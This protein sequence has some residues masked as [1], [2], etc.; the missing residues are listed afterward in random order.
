MKPVAILIMLLAL[1]AP[2]AAQTTDPADDE[3]PLARWQADHSVVMNADEVDLATFQWIAR[4]VVVFAD[5][6]ADPRFSEQMELIASNPGAL[7]ERDVV[8]VTD[9]DPAAGSM[10]REKLHPRGFSLVLI[11][12]DGTVVLRRPFPQHV[13]ELS[14][15]IDKLP[16]REQ[17]ARDRRTGG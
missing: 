6:A 13:R 12:K 14:R 1:T 9:T 10:V 7:A 3:T 15:A 8:I 16:M 17:E 5:T 4:P 2:V 11:A